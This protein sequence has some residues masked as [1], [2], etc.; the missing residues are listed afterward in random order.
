ME[1]AAHLRKGFLFSV[2][3]MFCIVFHVSIILNSVLY[4]TVTFRMYL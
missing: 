1:Q 2:I 4:E 3:D